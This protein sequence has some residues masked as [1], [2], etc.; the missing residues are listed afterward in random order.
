MHYPL[1]SYLPSHL[2]SQHP[3]YQPKLQ[4]KHQEHLRALPSH[5]TIV[6]GVSNTLLFFYLGVIGAISFYDMV[7]TVRYAESLKQLEMNPVGRWL[8]QL[9]HIPKNSIPDV[10]LFLLAKAFGTAIVLLVIFW[11]TRRRARLGHPIGMGVSLCQIL[12]AL[13]LCYGS[14]E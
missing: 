4:A 8:M 13:Y 12:L 11:I 10:S 5:G 7:L 6:R 2:P 3:E 1:E 9:D 14:L